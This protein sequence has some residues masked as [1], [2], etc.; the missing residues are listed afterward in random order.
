V[1][2]QVK[3]DVDI[4]AAWAKGTQSVNFE[5]ERVAGRTVSG[6]NPGIEPFD[7]PDLQDSALRSSTLNKVVRFLN[8]AGY[9]LL[10]ENIHAAIECPLRYGRVIGGRHNN[11]NSLSSGQ[12]VIETFEGGHSKFSCQFLCPL[13]YQV[14]DTD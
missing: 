1:D 14:V 6:D 3:H 11:T 13:G 4:E 8:R 10:K 9:R 5:K 2:H 7:M 12:G